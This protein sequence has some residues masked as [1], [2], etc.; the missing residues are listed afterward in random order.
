[1]LGFSIY[2][3]QSA[4]TVLQRK[5]AGVRIACILHITVKPLAIQ[6]VRMTWRQRLFV[7]L[8]TGWS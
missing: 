5:I 3:E 1:M 7:L 4:I 8:R 6:S 2:S